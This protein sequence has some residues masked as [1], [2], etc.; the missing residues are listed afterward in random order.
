MATNKTPEITP[1][2]FDAIKKGIVD[3]IKEK[4]AFTDYDF[5]GSALN[6]IIEML[7]YNTHYNAFYANMLHNEGFL[8][9]A[10][11][12]S[13]VVSRAKE[14]GY[15]P[16]SAFASTAYVDIKVLGITSTTNTNILLNRGTA[17]KS[18]NDNGPFTFMTTKDY[19]LQAEGTEF[20]FRNV[21]LKCGTFVT[22]TYKVID[23]PTEK[24]YFTIPN[25][26]IDLSTLRVLVRN[27]AS[28][29][30]YDEYFYEPDLT[31]VTPES[32]VFYL[33]ESFGE[34]Y[35]FY[36]G[37]D[38]LGVK[39]STSAV[40]DISYMIATKSVA[41]GCRTF[42]Y[43]GTVGPSSGLLISTLTPSFGGSEKETV[44]SIKEN[45]IKS[46]SNLKRAVTA[47]DYEVLIKSKFPYIKNASVYGGESASPPVYGKVFISLQPKD[48]L[49]I[50]DSVQKLEIEPYVNSIKVV[51]TTPEYVD[52]NFSFVNVKTNV[53]FDKSKS[54]N[55]PAGVEALVKSVITSYFDSN[56]NTFAKDFILSDFAALIQNVD[57]GII[58][59]DTSFFGNQRIFPTAGIPE[60]F[61]TNVNNRLVPG[62]I[63]TSVFV[64]N[65]QGTERNVIIVDDPLRLTTN[66]SSGFIRTY[67]TLV[68][69][70]AV[71]KLPYFDCGT[72]EYFYTPD[73]FRSGEIQFE[74]TVSSFVSVLNNI[75]IYY[76]LEALDFISSR[77]QIIQL[78]TSVEALDLNIKPGLGVTLTN[79]VS[80]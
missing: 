17:F 78:D 80:R 44:A 53:K 23:T 57:S 40:I 79:Y 9:T 66:D 68:V 26:D 43:D 24:Q 74:I 72:V 71:S 20:Y 70:D 34:L 37:D 25:R 33:Q 19:V 15:L 54:A 30:V 64:V 28:S 56:V 38:I 59:N 16:A 67:G 46:Y 4:P 48:G 5:S 58:S 13:S 50:S 1:L 65:V 32:K 73:E 63:E 62:S 49:F 35:Q 75:Y 76:R 77:N 69:V 10:Q 36:F 18:N 61:I 8:D 31:K 55:S 45:A 51:T 3:Y 52:P 6:T 12:R 42:T 27:S 47:E 41:N 11:K 21:E 29:V 14:L 22:N 2:E 60:K 7:A 39:P